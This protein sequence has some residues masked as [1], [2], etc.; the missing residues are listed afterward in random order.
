MRVER[1]DVLF[2]AGWLCV[3]AGAYLMLGLGPALIVFGVGLMLGAL[4]SAVREA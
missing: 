1:C 4:M 3:L 2:L